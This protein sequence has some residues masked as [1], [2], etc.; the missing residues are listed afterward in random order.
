MMDRGFTVLNITFITHFTLMTIMGVNGKISI[1][2]QIDRGLFI[3]ACDQ[4]ESSVVPCIG[5][6]DD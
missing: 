6:Y 5:R 3:T 4:L 2:S 1:S